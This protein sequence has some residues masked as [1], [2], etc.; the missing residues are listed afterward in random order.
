MLPY[1]VDLESRFDINAFRPYAPVELIRYALGASDYWAD[2]ALGWL[3]D[4]VP[5]RPLIEELK[6]LEEQA[7]RPQTLRHRARH[8]RKRA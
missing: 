8:L 5:S 4:G 7:D 6:A 3:E 2:L 1:L